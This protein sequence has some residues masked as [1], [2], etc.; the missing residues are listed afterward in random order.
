MNLSPSSF[1]LLLFIC[2]A[3]PSWAQFDKE[4]KI[5]RDTFANGDVKK[6]TERWIKLYKKGP[7]EDDFYRKETTKTI[8]Y[9]ESGKTKERTKSILLIG[10][11]G[12]ACAEPIYKRK[13]W[14][15]SGEKKYYELRRCDLQKSLIKEYDK[16]GRLKTR[17]LIEK[18]Y[19]TNH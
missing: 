9:F 12:R 5:H 17:T 6:V 18:P 1:L 13:S 16:K 7:G 19:R 2:L 10:T 3:A 4:Y 11:F 14:Y 15:A 8:E